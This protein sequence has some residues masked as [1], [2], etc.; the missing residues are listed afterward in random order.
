M[1]TVLARSIESDSCSSTKYLQRAQNI[2]CMLHRL[3][4]FH[5]FMFWGVG[6]GEAN[7]YIF[8]SLL[9]G[10]TKLAIRVELRLRKEL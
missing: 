8:P 4:F 1:I 7:N 9:Q 10:S 2:L 6:F 3:H 5:K